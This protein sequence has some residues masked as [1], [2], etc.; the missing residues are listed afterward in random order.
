MIPGIRV[1]TVKGNEANIKITHPIDLFIAEKLLQEANKISYNPEDDLSF[2]KNKN[3]VIFGGSSGIGLE[4]K[5]QQF[6]WAQMWM[7]QVA[8]I[9][10]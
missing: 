1:A 2:L 10:M 5:I 9:I 4:I 3:L 8:L 6:C 7:L